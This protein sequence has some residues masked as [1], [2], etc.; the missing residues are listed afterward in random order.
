MGIKT[1]D[2]Y[3]SL[4]RGYVGYAD[5]VVFAALV[6]QCQDP[7]MTKKMKSFL[8]DLVIKNPHLR[9]DF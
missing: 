5:D 2:G 1:K 3:M 6:N 9:K 4:V 8:S 7:Q